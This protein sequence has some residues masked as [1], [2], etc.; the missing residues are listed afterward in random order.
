MNTR[1]IAFSL[2]TAV[3]ICLAASQVTA[4]EPAAANAVAVLHLANLPDRL[5]LTDEY[6]YGAEADC[7]VM[8][9][10]DVSHDESQE[11]AA[12]GDAFVCI[13]ETCE[14]E[15][16]AVAAGARIN[17]LLDVQE[18]AADLDA[19]DDS[20][21]AFDCVE[22]F[23]GWI[24]ERQFEVQELSQEETPVA[25][26]VEFSDAVAAED[27]VGIDETVVSADLAEE[28][29]TAAETENEPTEY[30]AAE[31]RCAEE[32]DALSREPHDVEVTLEEFIEEVSQQFTDEEPVLETTEAGDARHEETPI[33]VESCEDDY[34]EQELSAVDQVNESD[35]VTVRTIDLGDCKVTVESERQIDDYELLEMLWQAAHQLEVEMD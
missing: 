29:P 21:D 4:G 18:V 6:L 13:D 20:V 35:A 33:L 15:R 19:D 16:I 8:E 24:V 3:G 5:V 34:F 23:D 2:T 1:L 26:T 31:D 12:E 32:I 28:V 22:G 27:N 25:E 10:A 9:E 11:P 17:E 14:S 30:V 7:F